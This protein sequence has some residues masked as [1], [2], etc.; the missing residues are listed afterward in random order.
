MLLENPVTY[1]DNFM[2]SELKLT[3]LIGLNCCLKI[4][5]IGF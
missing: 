2:F 5:N 3:G 4:Q 1:F